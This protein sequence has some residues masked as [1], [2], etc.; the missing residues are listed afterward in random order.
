[1]LTR[2]SQPAVRPRSL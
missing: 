2:G 1:M